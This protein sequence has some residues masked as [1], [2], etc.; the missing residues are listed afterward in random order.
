[1]IDQILEVVIIFQMSLPKDAPKTKPV[2]H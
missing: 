1:L 2:Y